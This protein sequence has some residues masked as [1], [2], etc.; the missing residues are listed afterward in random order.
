MSI[1]DVLRLLS[2]LINSRKSPK[3][4]EVRYL[5]NAKFDKLISLNRE[6][7]KTPAIFF[8]FDRAKQ[9]RRA[10]IKH[11]IETMLN[12]RG[13]DMPSVEEEFGSTGIFLQIFYEI[14]MLS[15]LW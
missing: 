12:I 15:F 10:M 5:F 13:K 11:Q 9:S 2:K 14:L 3:D 1:Y 4:N 7:I 8:T 6:S